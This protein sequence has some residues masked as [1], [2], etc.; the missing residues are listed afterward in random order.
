MCIVNRWRESEILGQE[1]NPRI[2]FW[3]AIGCRL[4]CLGFRCRG[5]WIWRRY[6][7]LRVKVSDVYSL[8]LVY[9]LNVPVVVAPGW[10]SF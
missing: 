7:S 3:R 2:L 1:Y 8:I 9:P 4:W 10:V 5:G 6:P